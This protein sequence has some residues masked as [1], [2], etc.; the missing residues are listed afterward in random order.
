MAGCLP[1]SG[2]NRTVFTTPVFGFSLT[3]GQW[4]KGWLTGQELSKYKTG[5]LVTRSFWGINPHTY[6]QL[7]YDKEGKNMQW[8]KDSFFSKW[9]WA[10][11]TAACKSMKLEHSLTLYT[12]I[13]SKWLKDL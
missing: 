3:H 13:D 5:K 4:L 6:G 10:S 1:K 2:K 9:C 8:R 7:T 11:W 12:N